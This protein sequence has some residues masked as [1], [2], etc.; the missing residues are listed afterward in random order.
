M[1]IIKSFKLEYSFIKI[2]LSLK[3]YFISICKLAPYIILS[4]LGIVS[5]ELIDTIM[6]GKYSINELA[7]YG[8]ATA[9]FIVLLVT[10]CGLLQG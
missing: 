3:K 10:T 1:N 5:M 4:K 7:Y 6:I 8:M 2:I 9:P